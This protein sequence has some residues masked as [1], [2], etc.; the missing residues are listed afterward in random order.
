ME[1]VKEKFYEV[2]YDTKLDKLVIKKERLISKIKRW[3]RVHKFMSTVIT[4]FIMFS[5]VNVIMIYNFMKILQ[6]V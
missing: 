4:T 2:M 1:G 5:T 6:N 3:I